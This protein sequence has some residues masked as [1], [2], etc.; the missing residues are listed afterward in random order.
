MNYVKESSHS[1]F[2]RAILEGL[3]HAVSIVSDLYVQY[4]KNLKS[5]CSPTVA[6]PLPLCFFLYTVKPNSLFD[7]S[8]YCSVQSQVSAFI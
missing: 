4:L 1:L 6:H 3:E 5:I 8:E 2:Y 7:N